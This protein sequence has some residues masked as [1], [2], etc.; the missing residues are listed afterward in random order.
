MCTVLG[1]IEDNNSI[2]V[3][4][5]SNIVKQAVFNIRKPIRSVR[6]IYLP[7]D[8]KTNGLMQYMSQGKI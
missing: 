7:F 4:G 5:T 2:D 8:I 3:H 6:N 1:Q